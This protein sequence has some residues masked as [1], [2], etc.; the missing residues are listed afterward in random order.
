[1]AAN[2]IPE[3]QQR[4]SEHLHVMLTPSE[5]A[6]LERLATERAREGRRDGISGVVRD[7]LRAL[8]RAER[9]RRP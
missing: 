7:G 2:G 8:F 3:D 5:R 6:K 1:M 9:G 4:L